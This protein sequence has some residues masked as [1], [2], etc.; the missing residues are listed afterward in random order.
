M[1]WAIILIA[2]LVL[3]LLVVVSKVKIYV[4]YRHNKDDDLLDAKVTFWGMRVYTFSAPVIKIDD[5]SASL[6]VEEEQKIAG[7]E[8]KKAL[9]IT[10][11]LL[12]K[13]F[14]WFKDFLDHV[15][16]LHKIVRKFLKKV[17]VNSLTWHTDIGVGDAAHTAQLAGAI[18]GVKGNIIGLI[19]NYMR[20]KFMPKLTID[21][22]FQ[23]M[24]SH[25][26]F[27][28][29]FSF[30]IGHAIVAGLMLLKHW[31]RRPKLSQSESVEKNM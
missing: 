26:Y 28:C 15:V 3:F 13:Y 19:G 5:D 4:D 16:G 7:F 18:W 6:I 22:H 24:V 10:P 8:T 12:D 27:S 20:M 17:N 29:M 2:L 14:H 11:E 21:P 1:V 9:P 30:R 23:A 25:T 31:R